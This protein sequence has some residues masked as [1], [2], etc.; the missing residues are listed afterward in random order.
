[1]SASQA[2]NWQ[3]TW[4]QNTNPNNQ[5]NQSPNH[6]QKVKTKTHKQWITTGEKIIYSFFSVMIVVALIFVVGFSSN[7]D[8]LNREVQQL[9]QNVKQQQLN[10]ENLQI[11]VKEYSNPDR[12]LQIAKDNGLKIQNTQVKQATSLVN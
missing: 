3:Q 4:Q 12:I 7:T 6:E 10:N 11:K 1:M 5:P 8:A 2:R 9:E